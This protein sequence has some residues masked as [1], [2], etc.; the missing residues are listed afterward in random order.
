[1]VVGEDDSGGVMFEGCFDDFAW[2]DTA[3]V[4]GDAEQF[5]VLDNTVSVVQEEAGE[6][7]V[8]F[9]GEFELD[10]VFRVLRTTKDGF[11][12]VVVD[13]AFENGEGGL[14]DFFFVLMF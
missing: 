3:S 10:V 7:F 8:R 1:M 12:D 9:V 4:D 13:A 2:V 5:F 11:I 14:D 6:D